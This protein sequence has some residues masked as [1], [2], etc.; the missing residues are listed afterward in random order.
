MKKEYWSYARYANFAISFGITMAISIFLGY[1]G[2]DWLDRQLG[3]RPVFLVVGILLGV[4]LSFK[5][6][7]TELTS[8]QKMENL[9]GDQDHE[10]K[11][12]G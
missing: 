10:K 2:G 5:M 11:G 7:L 1:F 8:L 3:T 9:P 6:L 4:A 12:E